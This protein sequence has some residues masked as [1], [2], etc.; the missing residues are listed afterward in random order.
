MGSISSLLFLLGSLQVVITG[1]LIWIGLL[2]ML[3]TF[4]SV[5]WPL[6]FIGFPTR[7]RSAKAL[8][9]SLVLVLISGVVYSDSVVFR[10]YKAELTQAERARAIE[11][12][13]SDLEQ[14]CNAHYISAGQKYARKIVRVTGIVHT[15]GEGSDDDGLLWF[16]IDDSDSSRIGATSH[17]VSKSVLA[18]GE[19]GQTLTVTCQ[20]VDCVSGLGA[21]LSNCFLD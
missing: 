3:V 15:I 16:R 21:I 14:E 7:K 1:L 5:L 10:V 12:N 9:V 19:P 20:Y 13:A 6:P 11:V 2:A 8:G 4:V 17:S 18:A